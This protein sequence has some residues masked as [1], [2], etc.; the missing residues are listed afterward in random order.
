VTDEGDRRYSIEELGL[1]ARA[2]H[3]IRTPM[4]GIVGLIELLLDTSLTAEQRRSAELI[5]ISIDSLLTLLNDILDFSKLRSEAVELESIPFDLAALVDSTVRLLSVRAFER[6]LDI[7][8]DIHPDV[9]RMVRGDPSRLRQILI[10]LVGNAVKFTHE[11]RVTVRVSPD[12]VEADA[13]RVRFDVEDTGIGI[14]P[15]K[16]ETIFQE[17]G[18]A[19][20][21]TSRKYGGTGLGLPIARRLAELMGGSLSVTSEVGVGS[22]FTFRV[23]VARTSRAE[24]DATAGGVPVPGET[25]VLVLDDTPSDRSFV[26]RV[27][28]GTGMTV[29]EATTS[30][31]ALQELRG[32]RSSGVPY[33]LIVLDSWVGGEDGFEIARRIRSDPALAGVRVMMLSATGRRGDG[34]RCRAL[35]IHAYFVMPL[36]EDD[37]VSAVSA[38]LLAPLGDHLVTRHSIEE[39][40]RRLRVLV[41]DDNEVNRVVTMAILEKRGHSVNAVDNGRLAVARARAEPYDVILMDVEMPDLDGVAATAALRAEPATE[42]VPIIAMT[43][44]TGFGESPR[45]RSARMSAFLAKP[46]KPQELIRMVESLG[47]ATP[48]ARVT[49]G[50]GL[51]SAPVNLPEF[52]RVMREAGIE[53]T[54]PRILQVF[55]EDA[56]GRMAELEAAVASRDGGEIRMAAHA[57]KSAATTIR[58]ENLAVLLSEIERSGQSGDVH[59]AEELVAQARSEADSVLDYLGTVAR[60]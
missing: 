7:S 35:G 55:R 5:K 49:E 57:F 42:S 60:V 32:T 26:A 25:R 14:A 4:N 46:F 11:G 13:V 33:H 17:F 37:L 36:S 24:H 28:A 41:A 20:A 21:S 29:Y 27:L 39:R 45:Y 6:K 56:P 50:H 51:S 34:Q 23:V 44:H 15:D 3:E 31:E 10:N 54:V 58:A 30:V 16:L 48:A 43:A 59:H 22:T 19:E 18:Q 52:Q 8:Y 9:P 47:A 12:G 53:T 1:L 2:S 40:R 38:A